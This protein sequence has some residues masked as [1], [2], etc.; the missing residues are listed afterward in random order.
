MTCIEVWTPTRILGCVEDDD[1]NAVDPFVQAVPDSNYKDLQVQAL[2]RRYRYAVCD[3]LNIERWLQQIKD[4]AEEVNRRYLMMFAAYDA[5]DLSDMKMGYTDTVDETV[6]TTGKVGQQATASSTGT[7]TN[8]TE[9]EDLPQ[10]EVANGKF[11]SGRTTSTTTPGTVDTSAR[12]ST[13]KHDTQDVLLA[14]EYAQL[15]DSLR[16]PLE[17]YAGEFSDLFANR[18]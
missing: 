13:M 10:S 16:D 17:R 8:K 14:E 12:K 18:W 7:G 5:N 3:S 9:T 4:R 15:M 1:G 11:L 6:A 2:W